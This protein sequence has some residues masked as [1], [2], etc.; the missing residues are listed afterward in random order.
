FSGNKT[1][2]KPYE[3]DSATG[4]AGEYQG[5]GGM[6]KYEISAGVTVAVNVPGQAL[7]DEIFKALRDLHEA[8]ESDDL[9]A[10]GG[11]AMAG[12]DSAVDRLPR[13]R[14]DGGARANR[15]ARAAARMHELELNVEQL[16]A[17][18]E[19]VDIAGAIIDLKVSEISYRAAVASGA[20]IIQ[21][22]RIDF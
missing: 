12:I 6:R 10:V 2:T 11:S 16:S 22:T 15:L 18:N 9:D 3:L 19:S 20:R 7:F 13:V 1:L 21:P 4:Y 5:D 8:L 17:D 14:T